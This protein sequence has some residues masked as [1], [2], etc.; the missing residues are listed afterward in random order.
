MLDEFTEGPLTEEEL[1]AENPLGWEIY[2]TGYELIVAL[3]A[4]F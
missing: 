3:G 2:N 1:I 4:D